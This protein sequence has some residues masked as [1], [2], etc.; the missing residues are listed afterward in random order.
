MCISFGR[1]VPMMRIISAI[2]VCTFLW[3][4]IVFAQGGPQENQPVSS[5]VSPSKTDQFINLR[6][7][8][9]PRNLG[10]T[11]EVRPFNSKE[12]IINIKD[13]HDN[14]SAQESIVGLL[15]NLV[16][17]YD[18]RTIA[19]EGSA[20][21][22]DTSIISS[23]PDREIKKELSDRLMAEGLI[24][25]AEYYSIIT[26][27]GAA[28]YGIDDKKMHAED[29]DAFRTCLE[30]RGNNYKKARALY[31]CL[32]ALEDH[33]YSNELK[34]LETNSILKNNGSI[35]FTNRWDNIRVIGE[36]NGIKPANF[37]NINSLLKA[38]ELE[39]KCNFNSTNTERT[40]LMNDLK[41]V[42]DKNK[43]EE[44]I[45]KSISFK[46]GKIS[47][48]MYYSHL[49]DLARIEK[50]DLEKRYP[51]ILTYVEYMTLYESVDINALKDEVIDYENHIKEKIFRNNDERK[52]AGLLRKASILVDLIEVKLTST[53]LKYFDKHRQ[54]FTA[55]EFTDFIRSMHARYEIRIPADLDISGVFEAM[56]A[57]ER[58]YELTLKRND[59]MVANTIKRMRDKGETVAALITGGF[60]TEGIAELLKK[61][62]L[63]YLIILPKFDKDKTRP[64]MTIITNK[65]KVYSDLTE[66]GD[67]YIALKTFFNNPAFLKEQ[68]E[69]LASK[70]RE[71]FGEK[72]TW[73]TI[74][75]LRDYTDLYRKAQEA[76]IKAG[77]ITREQAEK[78]IVM[79]GK[80]IQAMEGK[81]KEEAAP[82][83]AAPA[84][85]VKQAIAEAEVRRKA[86]QAVRAKAD[87]EKAASEAKA[88]AEAE[89]QKAAEL[90][91]QRKAEVE[92]ELAAKAEAEKKAIEAA[93]AKATSI[94]KQDK[95]ALSRWQKIKRGFILFLIAVG[96]SASIVLFTEYQGGQ[97]QERG[98]VPAAAKIESLR[99][100]DTPGF[101]NERSDC[102]R[103]TEQEYKELQNRLP[104][105]TNVSYN[106][107][108]RDRLSAKDKD[109]VAK[110]IQLL[111]DTDAVRAIKILGAIKHLLIL[112][113]DYPAMALQG[114]FVV[115]SKRHL[116][117]ITNDNILAGWA[118]CF[119]HEGRHLLDASE[120]KSVFNQT[121]LS[122]QAK[123]EE[124]AYEETLYWTIRFYDN[125]SVKAQRF[126]YE[127]IKDAGYRGLMAS[128]VTARTSLEGDAF[129]MVLGTDRE[130]A[131]I[132]KEEL[133]KGGRI[134]FLGLYNAT[135]RGQQCFNLEYK[136]GE[137][138][139]RVFLFSAGKEDGRMKFDIGQPSEITKEDSVYYSLDTQLS[140][141]Q[142]EENGAAIRASGENLN[143]EE[144]QALNQAIAELIDPQAHNVGV[145]EGMT[146]FAIM[147][148]MVRFKEIL[149]AKINPSTGKLY[150]DAEAVSAADIVAHAGHRR[151]S[152][153]MD[154]DVYDKLKDIPNALAYIAKH[155]KGHIDEYLKRMEAA[156]YTEREYVPD[157]VSSGF[158][159]KESELAQDSESEKAKQ[160]VIDLAISVIPGWET[161]ARQAEEAAREKAEAAARQAQAPP[162][163]AAM[164]DEIAE[165]KKAQESAKEGQETLDLD[166]QQAKIRDLLKRYK[167]LPK[168][169]AE[170]FQG[171]IEALNSF[172]MLVELELIRWADHKEQAKKG[173]KEE[174]AITVKF[175]GKTLSIITTKGH[176][177]EMLV[178][179][180]DAAAE[181]LSMM[182]ATIKTVEDAGKLSE[183]AKI[184]VIEGN[185]EWLGTLM[186]FVKRIKGENSLDYENLKKYKEALVRHRDEIAQS[187][188]SARKTRKGLE[189]IEK[190]VGG[191]K[192]ITNNLLNLL[193]ESASKDQEDFRRTITETFYRIQVRA[194]R[195]EE[196]AKKGKVRFI[197]NSEKRLKEKDIYSVFMEFFKNL[198]SGFVT[199]E[200]SKRLLKDAIDACEKIR[201]Y[202]GDAIEKNFNEQ[203]LIIIKA[204]RKLTGGDAADTINKHLESKE[205]SKFD[206]SELPEKVAEILRE[207][208]ITG[209]IDTK[210]C[211]DKV[212]LG[213]EAE[214]TGSLAQYITMLAIMPGFEKV[215]DSAGFDAK[216]NELGLTEKV[217]TGRRLFSHLAKLQEDIAERLI[218]GDKLDPAKATA[219]QLK[220]HYEMAAVM[221]IAM[222]VATGRI[223]FTEQILTSIYGDMGYFV[224]MATGSGK[225]LAFPLV[226]LLRP[227]RGLKSFHL[228]TADYYTVRD[229]L[230]TQFIY[231]LFGRDVMTV[232]EAESHNLEAVMKSMEDNNIIFMSFNVLLTL[233]I[234]ALQRSD[235]QKAFEDILKDAA[236]TIDECDFALRLHDMIISSKQLGLSLSE[237]VKNLI[238]SI[239]TREIR[240][241]GLIDKLETE[242]RKNRFKLNKDNIETAKKEFGADIA[243]DEFSVTIDGRKIDK[244]MTEKK[245]GAE[246]KT[247]GGARLRIKYMKDGFVVS[248]MEYKGEDEQGGLK[249]Y[250]DNGGR[251]ICDKKTKEAIQEILDSARMKA[252]VQLAGKGVIVGEM[253]VDALMDYIKGFYLHEE[254][255]DYII[256]FVE[257]QGVQP[258]NLTKD[259]AKLPDIEGIEAVHYNASDGSFDIFVNESVKDAQTGKDVIRKIN[260]NE[261]DIKEKKEGFIVIAIRDKKYMVKKTDSGFSLT[262]CEREITLLDKLSGRKQTGVRQDT[263]HTILEMKH[264]GDEALKGFGI[265]VR[266][267]NESMEKT[268]LPIIL[269]KMRQ[270]CGASGSVST[271]ANAVTNIFD[272]K[273][274]VAMDPHFE[275]KDMRA[276]AVF[277]VGKRMNEKMTLA[278][279]QRM[280]RHSPGSSAIVY[281]D[282]RKDAEEYAER[283]RQL[284]EG[285]GYIVK[286][287]TFADEADEFRLVVEAG[288]LGTITVTTS[289]LGRATDVQPQSKDRIMREFKKLVKDESAAKQLS[290][291][292]DELRFILNPAERLSGIDRIRGFLDDFGIGMGHAVYKMIAQKFFEGIILLNETPDN[293]DETNE[294]KKGRTARAGNP[295]GSYDYSGINDDDRAWELIDTAFNANYHPEWKEWLRFWKRWEGRAAAKK[296]KRAHELRNRLADLEKQVLDEDG[297]YLVADGAVFEEWV[298]LEHE[299]QGLVDEARKAYQEKLDK[300]AINKTEADMA[301]DK[302]MQSIRDFPDEHLK[303]EKSLDSFL[304]T[305]ID[306]ILSKFFNKLKEGESPDISR[307]IDM[308]S[309]AFNIS[310][311]GKYQSQRVTTRAELESLKGAIRR[312]MI[313]AVRSV[314][315]YDLKRGEKRT[316]SVNGRQ[317]ELTFDERAL[318]IRD[319]Q[320][321]AEIRITISGEAKLDEYTKI[322]VALSDE[323]CSVKFAGAYEAVVRDAARFGLDLVRK[324]FLRYSQE[325]TWLLVLKGKGAYIRDIRGRSRMLMGN[326]K[327]AMRTFAEAISRESEKYLREREGRGD[328]Y[329]TQENRETIQEIIPSLTL[330]IS[331]AI[332]ERAGKLAKESRRQKAD[333]DENS[334]NWKEKG[335]SK[336]PVTVAR[337]MK[338]QVRS[339]R[340]IENLGAFGQ[341]QAA[342]AVGAER[343]EERGKG[344][345]PGK[346]LDLSGKNFQKKDTSLEKAVRE[347]NE[348]DKKDQARARREKETKAKDF[349]KDK[350][351]VRDGIIEVDGQ[352][353]QVATVEGDVTQAAA[354]QAFTRVKPLPLPGGEPPE[355]NLLVVMPA[356]MLST[357]PL[358]D[359]ELLKNIITDL[360]ARHKMPV[361]EDNRPVIAYFSGFDN[362]KAVDPARG[363]LRAFKNLVIIDADSADSLRVSME[364]LSV[365][366]NLS[367]FDISQKE[368]ENL[369]A[370]QSKD[371]T[372]ILRDEKR[373]GHLVLNIDGVIFITFLGKDISEDF[374]VRVQETLDHL[375]GSHPFDK[376]MGYTAEQYELRADGLY[377][378]SER[379]ISLEGAKEIK[380]SA[381]VVKIEEKKPSW[382]EKWLYWWISW[383]DYL[384]WVG[385]SA[386]ARYEGMLKDKELEWK[387]TVWHRWLNKLESKYGEKSKFFK[388]ARFFLKMPFWRIWSWVRSGRI[389][390]IPAK[391]IIGILPGSVLIGWKIIKFIGTKIGAGVSNLWKRLFGKE[392]EPAED[393]VLGILPKEIRDA[394]EN[395]KPL[396]GKEA[397]ELAATITGRPIIT[398]NDDERKQLQDRISE[399]THL[400][401]EL[402]QDIFFRDSK[403]PT[404]RIAILIAY[405]SRKDLEHMRKEFALEIG[406]ALLRTYG[407]TKQILP[408][409]DRKARKPLVTAY[410]YFL[411]A[412]LID[413]KDARVKAHMG[414]ILHL[415]GGEAND[416]NA[417]EILEK[418]IKGNIRDKD[419]LTGACAILGDILVNE[420]DYREALKFYN[421]TQSTKVNIFGAEVSIPEK[422]KK[423][424]DELKPKAKKEDEFTAEKKPEKGKIGLIKRLLIPSG[425]D[426]VITGIL[427]GIL[428]AA[429]AIVGIFS[430]QAIPVI[431]KAVGVIPFIGPLLAAATGKLT[432][433]FSVKAALIALSSVYGA[434]S[435]LFNFVVKPL[436]SAGRLIV[437]SL[438]RCLSNPSWTR[439]MIKPALRAAAA[440][441]G[442]MKPGIELI[443][444]YEGLG[445][446]NKAKAV[447]KKMTSAIRKNK[448]TADEAM[449]F[450]EYLIERKERTA[451]EELFA[452]VWPGQE[453]N[454]NAINLRSRVALVAEQPDPDSAF[455]WAEEALKADSGNIDALLVKAEAL[456][457]KMVTDKSAKIRSEYNNVISLLK[458][459]AKSM[460]SRQRDRYE[461]LGFEQ[462]KKETT[463][464]E[465]GTSVVGASETDE[466]QAVER[467]KKVQPPEVK[468]YSGDSVE[469]RRK[470]ALENRIKRLTPAECLELSHI[471]MKESSYL[472][473][474]KQ[475]GRIKKIDTEAL[476]AAKLAV[477]CCLN[478]EERT[479]WWNRPLGI[480]HFTLRRAIGR[481][482]ALGNEE[483]ADWLYHAIIKRNTIEAEKMFSGVKGLYKQKPE[484]EAERNNNEFIL[485]GLK[486]LSKKMSFTAG[487][488]LKDALV[489]EGML[490]GISQ[491]EV[492]EEAIEKL[493]KSNTD[494]M[495]SAIESVSAG[496]FK[497]YLHDLRSVIEDKTMELNNLR[498]ILKEREEENLTMAKSAEEKE[499]LENKIEALKKEIKALEPRIMSLC[500]ILLRENSSSVRATEKIRDSISGLLE[501]S[502]QKKELTPEL[503]KKQLDAIQGIGDF[504]KE[505]IYAMYVR[506][507]IK[508]SF[509]P[510]SYSKEKAPSGIITGKDR[511]VG[512]LRELLDIY[513]RATNK[514]LKNEIKKFMT[515]EIAS[516]VSK[517][518]IYTNSWDDQKN[519]FTRVSIVDDL[520]ILFSGA[521][522]IA[523]KDSAYAL[524]RDKIK[525]IL[526]GRRS[527]LTE[528]EK[529]KAEG[530]DT[531][532]E[533]KEAET[534]LG[535][536]RGKLKKLS[537]DYRQE[538]G[539]ADE[540][541]QEA[542][543]EK[544]M[545]LVSLFYGFD[546]ATALKRIIENARSDKK[547][548]DI[549]KAK[550]LRVLGN[551]SFTFDSKEEFARAL[552]RK[553]FTLEEKITILRGCG[554]ILK[555]EEK[556]KIL[557]QRAKRYEGKKE[558]LV[559]TLK[560][561]LESTNSDKLT[562][563]IVNGIIGII[564]SL[565]HDDPPLLYKGIQIVGVI[566]KKKDDEALVNALRTKFNELKQRLVDALDKERIEEEKSEIKAVLD[567]A[568]R[569]MA[570]AAGYE[571]HRELRK[572]EEILK[573]AIDIVNSL[574]ERDMD[575]NSKGEKPLPS[576]AMSECKT[577]ATELAIAMKRILIKQDKYY[578]TELFFAR[579]QKLLARYEIIMSE[580]PRAGDRYR[581]SAR[582]ALKQADI[583]KPGQIEVSKEQTEIEALPLIVIRELIQKLSAKYDSKKGEAGR[584]KKR[585]KEL[586][587]EIAKTRKAIAADVKEAEINARQ[588][589]KVTDDE[590]ANRNERANNLIDKKR[591][592]TELR[593]ELDRL[594]AKKQKLD[595]D[596]ADISARKD[597]KERL[598]GLL[599]DDDAA[600]IN[601]AI[602]HTFRTIEIAGFDQNNA[603]VKNAIGF[604]GSLPDGFNG[605][606]IREI[607]RWQALWAALKAE[608]RAK[609]NRFIESLFLNMICKGR[610]KE[611]LNILNAIGES[612]AANGVKINVLGEEHLFEATALLDYIMLNA[613]K[614]D[615]PA[616]KKR[617][618][619]IYQ[620]AKD[621]NDVILAAAALK[622][623]LEMV[624][625]SDDKEL[626]NDAN[627][628]EK[629]AIK[630]G[631]RDL[632]IRRL[633]LL[634]KEQ[635]MSAISGRA[636]LADTILSFLAALKAGKKAWND[637]KGNK[638]DAIEFIVDLLSFEATAAAYKGEFCDML[639][640]LSE[641][642]KEKEAA[643]ERRLKQEMKKDNPDTALI[644]R[645]AETMLEIKP[646]SEIARYFLGAAL[647]IDTKNQVGLDEKQRM[648]R[649]VRINDMKS[650]LQARQDDEDA[651]IFFAGV[652]GDLHNTIYGEEGPA[653]NIEASAYFSELAEFFMKKSDEESIK[654]NDS[655]AKGYLEKALKYISFAIKYNER[656]GGLAIKKIRILI[657]LG[658]KENE[659]FARE[660]AKN[661]FEV[662]KLKKAEKLFKLIL[663]KENEAAASSLIAV[664]DIKDGK[665]EQAKD[666]LVKGIVFI[667]GGH[668]LFT[669]GRTA[670]EILTSLAL[671]HLNLGNTA[672]AKWY[673]DYAFRA[674]ARRKIAIDADIL[675]EV[676]V[677][678][679]ESHG[680]NDILMAIRMRENRLE[681]GSV[682]KEAENKRIADLY[683]RLADMKAPRHWWQIMESV[684]VKDKNRAAQKANLKSAKKADPKRSREIDDRIMSINN[685][686][687]AGLEKR[688]ELYWSR[689]DKWQFLRI[690]GWPLI[691]RFF[692][693][694]ATGR[695]VE[696][697][698]ENANLLFSELE[699]ETAKK[700][701]VRLRGDIEEELKALK[702]AAE[703]YRAKMPED[704]KKLIA[705]LYVSKADDGDDVFNNYAAALAYDNTNARARLGMALELEKKGAEA[706]QMAEHLER[707]LNLDPSLDPPDCEYS[708]KL[709]AISGIE[710]AKKIEESLIS[711]LLQEELDDLDSAIKSKEANVSK[712]DRII[713]ARAALEQLRKDIEKK[714]KDKE[715]ARPLSAYFNASLAIDEDELDRREASI[716]ATTGE[717]NDLLRKK[718]IFNQVIGNARGMPS[719]KAIEYL[720]AI[721]NLVESN[722]ALNNDIGIT[723]PLKL[724][725]VEY[726]SQKKDDKTAIGYLESI[727]NTIPG[728]PSQENAQYIIKAYT[729]LAGLIVEGK[730]TGRFK[731]AIERVK[732]AVD[733]LRKLDNE[734]KD[735]RL[736]GNIS[737]TFKEI[738]KIAKE[739]K[740]EESDKP[741]IVAVFNIFMP[742]AE[743]KELIEIITAVTL[744]D[745]GANIDI[746]KNWIENG[747]DVVRSVVLNTIV[748]HLTQDRNAINDIKAG[749]LNDLIEEIKGLQIALSMLK[750]STD[751]KMRSR[752]NLLLGLIEHEKGQARAFIKEAVMADNE[753]KNKELVLAALSNTYSVFRPARW[754][755]ARNLK[756]IARQSAATYKKNGDTAFN[757]KNYHKAV[758]QYEKA[759]KKEPSLANNNEF[760]GRLASA[761]QHDDGTRRQRLQRIISPRQ[762]TRR[763]RA[764]QW[765]ISRL[766]K[767]IENTKD[768]AQK[769][770]LTKEFIDTKDTMA[771]L[772]AARYSAMS[773]S[774]R[775]KNWESFSEAISKLYMDI[776]G[777]NITNIRYYAS[778]DKNDEAR[779]SFSKAQAAFL[780][781]INFG[782]GSEARK[783]LKDLGEKIPLKQ[784][785]DELIEKAQTAISKGNFEEAL[786]LIEEVV[787][788]DE[789]QRQ[790]TKYRSDTIEAIERII[791]GLLDHFVSQSYLRAFGAL[792][793]AN[794]KDGMRRAQAQGNFTNQLTDHSRKQHKVLMGIFER[795]FWYKD[796]DKSDKARREKLRERVNNELS[797]AGNAAPQIDEKIKDIFINRAM[798]SA[799]KLIEKGNE[800]EAIALISFVKTIIQA[801]DSRFSKIRIIEARAKVI[802]LTQD[803]D[804][805]LDAL[806]NEAKAA[807]ES[808]S[809]QSIEEN[810]AKSKIALEIAIL[811]SSRAGRLRAEKDRQDKEKALDLSVN[812]CKQALNINPANKEAPHKL[813]SLYR[814]AQKEADLFKD[815]TANIVKKAVENSDD[816]DLMTDIAITMLSVDKAIV[817]AE[818]IE[819][820]NAIFN[821]VN[822][823]KINAVDA[824]PMLDRLMPALRKLRLQQRGSISR[825][826]TGLAAIKNKFAN[827]EIYRLNPD[828]AV[829]FDLAEAYLHMANGENA[830]T[831]EILKSSCPRRDG[832]KAEF[833]FIKLRLHLLAQDMG[834]AEYALKALSVL[835]ANMTPAARIF[836]AETYKTIADSSEGTA[837]TKLL[838]KAVYYWP[839]FK[840]AHDSIQ[841]I[842]GKDSK[843]GSEEAETIKRIAKSK[844][845]NP[846]V[847]VWSRKKE[848]TIHVV[849]APIVERLIYFGI[850]LAASFITSIILSGLLNTG[851][852]HFLGLMPLGLKFNLM[853]TALQ[854]PFVY[855]FITRH[856][857]PKAAVWLISLGSLSLPLL[858]L[859]PLACLVISYGLHVVINLP[860]FVFN[861]KNNLLRYRALNYATISNDLSPAKPSKIVAAIKPFIVIGVVGASEDEIRALAAPAGVE[862][863][864][865]SRGGP[866]GVA[867]LKTR[868]PSALGWT[869]VD[870]GK[871]TP[872]AIRNIGKIAEK[873]SVQSL[874]MSPYMAGVDENNISG[875]TRTKLIRAF[876]II[877]KCLPEAK[878]LGADFILVD[879]DEAA[880]IN[881]ISFPARHEV[882]YSGLSPADTENWVRTYTGAIE[883][884]QN[885]DNLNHD[886]MSYLCGR[887]NAGENIMNILALHEAV[888]AAQYWESKDA[889]KFSETMIEEVRKNIPEPDGVCA[890]AYDVK[891]L[892]KPLA[893]K[894]IEGVIAAAAGKKF[895]KVVIFRDTEK[896]TIP[897]DIASKVTVVTRQSG[898]DDL[899]G[900]IKDE[901]R[902]PY[903]RV[904]ISM[905]DGEG[906]IGGIVGDL[907][908]KNLGNMPSYILTNR[909]VE[910]GEINLANLLRALLGKAPSFIALGYDKEFENLKFGEIKKILSGINGHFSF[911][912]NVSKA[913]SEIFYA[914]KSTA[915]SV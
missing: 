492:K 637:L 101:V 770:D 244:Q 347:A 643:L 851:L 402:S 423:C 387:N 415:L 854:I 755:I 475:L 451:A 418:A 199:D 435:I 867:D 411:Y 311:D 375:S 41:G 868:I 158:Y 207:F 336:K 241:K 536:A 274:V 582:K 370:L 275:K 495:R 712:L 821:R 406:R 905:R 668:I 351:R 429:L 912:T 335:E 799:E 72:K 619:D 904:A 540:K 818:R 409:P 636:E 840:E 804:K 455:H 654:G 366:A 290:S 438:W 703:Q 139:Y 420:K 11:K 434:A 160:A 560:E 506:L 99:I 264:T 909:D 647:Y 794:D 82:G 517:Y 847:F 22:V 625:I 595:K 617:L 106:D 581:E 669:I 291:L 245:D 534:A 871:M 157:S 100:F 197:S 329:N 248:R 667:L 67:Y 730:D 543:F 688:Q 606:T 337:G 137:Q 649:F 205:L 16:T 372:F 800:G 57:A 333:R 133:T 18:I 811:F 161:A 173:S 599:Y 754:G 49:V 673:L 383:Y 219:A 344:F 622:G 358:A 542:L 679:A 250:F 707:A 720:E 859:S 181:V 164:A 554:G 63:S 180:R 701:R 498:A 314:G 144:H 598:E 683:M 872:S 185:I 231:R 708:K 87:Q 845:L 537:D 228:V 392:K 46:L 719:E 64:Y 834:Q 68:A 452:I 303:D 743:D 632:M 865:L 466:V 661:I 624:G 352:R 301:T 23:F 486:A 549:I 437:R 644:K 489:I 30:E 607:K 446:P 278:K 915:I 897:E 147:G 14:L 445:V 525:G 251:V 629:G 696:I 338:E 91:A 312:E 240:E 491:E 61:D 618:W 122:S 573:K 907:Q 270:R 833:V 864:A 447:I 566:I 656:D 685:E 792:N 218:D 432:A 721:L 530:K 580:D 25:A 615:R 740:P 105:L 726:Y 584:I 512:Y 766:T 853:L 112:D 456:A 400:Y 118:L 273:G 266:G 83:K 43:L 304:E 95:E 490:S 556:L 587:K 141:A 28:L 657:K 682:N 288:E 368:L 550:S 321:G 515:D 694:D 349:A 698:L 127:H 172:L 209:E 663:E 597:G 390:N 588:A 675:N 419:M 813:I 135:Y 885:L 116:E 659:A 163:I 785:V 802:S 747:S 676:A 20:G 741:G 638:I 621:K 399:Y 48:S 441:Q 189:T 914:I 110:A 271:V 913:I 458:R 614:E 298:A 612:K 808:L 772:M 832:D 470:T 234:S 193:S 481:V 479:K 345:T 789:S 569:L 223:A 69:T 640:R 126:V 744:E 414:I 805:N 765:R 196:A 856:E 651:R 494:S 464:R 380:E 664:L 863:F 107:F 745:I 35:G 90:E 237:F 758:I 279:L 19:V 899:S 690:R 403:D 341:P 731:K 308:I 202:N 168:E 762:D 258:R 769:A 500:V 176:V 630:S 424:K 609:K 666:D 212:L 680:Y 583:I 171:D 729:L 98:A 302:E 631:K 562:Q 841:A 71:K 367:G 593:E 838:E 328:N 780:Q 224:D 359:D 374:E 169:K 327:R 430:P 768:E 88:R 355:T 325:K 232:M 831:I 272:I 878:T 672:R 75:A 763:E 860:V 121:D 803:K 145:F 179:A 472:K 166:S 645:L 55:Q 527:I 711:K 277:T 227:M 510:M 24:S 798:V 130:L 748:N 557:L 425:K 529:L 428:I 532:I 538:F 467:E 771:R 220:A 3:Q 1:S 154:A 535:D 260:V 623:L 855:S 671:A 65:N 611:V 330:N 751:E 31:Q 592:V 642:T 2:L 243:F 600:D 192:T 353:V 717:F 222:A 723:H 211:I 660:I 563:D 791:D 693:S 852:T 884:N 823:L 143:V 737:D 880:L 579:G 208:G 877:I 283:I 639:A 200:E 79:I 281:R 439:R 444:A 462:A 485:S 828:I 806:D 809:E 123:G 626:S 836:I 307:L 541:R 407:E 816:I 861:I 360:I 750:D 610:W 882:S 282:G 405:I 648:K 908:N 575:F 296:L 797:I 559:D 343:V 507:W 484:T 364:K 96:A 94:S 558:L 815:D 203:S 206:R 297:H 80:V 738:I 305:V 572:A 764:L 159:A 613:K 29:M 705:R 568:G 37:T 578:E 214:R 887:R 555:P 134:E 113:V 97:K 276:P 299:S 460:A 866:E 570:I 103:I 86:A 827:E 221:Q 76:K 511:I 340:V 34:T 108:I 488:R 280:L 658:G 44:L 564:G 117:A 295:G 886:L 229:S 574:F 120:G 752:A 12:I 204:V 591:A 480:R 412:S 892:G 356:A 13:A 73:D 589:E 226:N 483:L 149:K 602:R 60:H 146:L 790:V 518:A 230:E 398:K 62:K 825:T 315:N 454:I 285:A 317:W 627:F 697:H 478:I 150:T 6:E 718:E 713:R 677:K 662:W 262:E 699:E 167:I 875:L 604:L 634:F 422:Q 102:A 903:A 692:A 601:A 320:K 309:V 687:L 742:L 440:E 520:I 442:K 235:L 553:Q 505:M 215:I 47:A 129:W 775:R 186:I 162:E 633:M 471:Y 603:D 389:L 56:P 620:K 15:D 801:N 377:R 911:I 213:D 265:M 544:A 32:A 313:N 247:I 783:A 136:I 170:T 397:L 497:V 733:L 502:A 710:A 873:M 324:N 357:D 252:M 26:E 571:E 757:N 371:K 756:R 5:K 194:R 898:N 746:L 334:E 93:V 81:L 363:A 183:S 404:V 376:K 628:D 732:E 901:L 178:E 394:I 749:R 807:L 125:N 408:E 201:N 496:R 665:A 545:E 761:Y 45:L 131:N 318:T 148:L 448:F 54:E 522:D 239:A 895:L 796:G 453:K 165:I 487:N 691:R 521:G 653:V 776:G 894:N 379:V 689:R 846:P 85:M 826:L 910:I 459:Q 188:K 767:A 373:N 509:E 449:L 605:P 348:R 156:G 474:L 238:Y 779:E 365:Q 267:S 616:L 111:I 70:L 378:N 896:D 115:M 461:A 132:Y 350:I 548:N 417:K 401:I 501:R 706:S 89:R 457:K 177:D 835:N 187:G 523:I 362:V 514:V 513:G 427:A 715:A 725:I 326:T 862:F 384:P 465:L 284:L 142:G 722:S 857:G 225:T 388:A 709:F 323:S 436:F 678:L 74:K 869:L 655:A 585:I 883:A 257:S 814:E 138:I 842:V 114:G 426:A 286:I 294:Q 253:T 198:S 837:K 539:Q 246:V 519:I 819:I 889:S 463:S 361:K 778:I 849:R 242:F 382:I 261:K 4:E 576:D 346:S 681:A 21:Y 684:K 217:Q 565:P 528:A 608:E 17:N 268:T 431:I 879:I 839:K 369:F 773:E 727:I 53:S 287:N 499:K 824:V 38:I 646:E 7:F 140:Y 155:E 292:L 508:S 695:V 9:I 531:G 36:K 182:L 714:S 674:A 175:G 66:N 902:Y 906:V 820:L 416:K 339:D 650:Y 450:I 39:K 50:M 774:K 670:P 256:E 255:V 704:Y 381:R 289:M 590:G 8:S 876:D 850:P 759:L 469:G 322:D 385:L 10:T 236:A 567:E 893:K 331:G 848:F 40:A 59:V 84:E 795:W 306:Y 874:L 191:L 493:K 900:Q 300:Q 119:M 641:D 190:S 551:I 734:Y 891:W 524:R 503:F 596:M 724:A 410:N 686:E 843:R 195:F 174:V 259:T 342:I 788:K 421:R 888:A 468:K 386:V 760:A 782:V 233:Y 728:E 739:A 787:K 829:V 151:G 635:E 716:S 561:F 77:E 269:R 413:K 433:G 504:E 78:N 777:L 586:A 594:N 546:A 354:V 810:A 516:D 870:I 27:S 890:L 473:A 210:S 817:S 781:A 254:G 577:R 393:E 858:N 42:L 547:K 700:E 844:D 109:T 124:S 52:L 735:R 881:S 652:Y 476:E 753:M 319:A 310:L 33:I 702:A 391:L 92:K 736:A 128:F 153:Y 526:E 396:T 51:N 784:S 152:I 786:A 332:G 184:W 830:E 293:N 477:L 822:L 58:F 443:K 216:I 395:G 249:F 263:F 316:V 552:L 533:Y 482:R 793:D 812:Y 104:E